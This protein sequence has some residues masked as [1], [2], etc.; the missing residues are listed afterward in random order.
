MGRGRN[1]P[2]RLALAAPK[3]A[4]S[5][6]PPPPPPQAPVAFFE[7]WRPGSVL[8]VNYDA[9][10]EP[11]FG[12]ILLQHVERRDW[13]AMTPDMVRHLEL[14]V[15][16]YLQEVR[17]GRRARELLSGV[18]VAFGA[19]PRVL[20]RQYVAAALA[21]ADG[22]SRSG[23]EA[24][25]SS[26]GQVPAAVVR[27]A[28]AGSWGP[29]RIVGGA[30]SSSSGPALATVGSAPGWCSLR[31]RG[32]EDGILHDERLHRGHALLFVLLGYLGYIAQLD[33]GSLS[34][35][36]GM[37]GQLQFP[38]RGAQEA[39]GV[40]F[41]YEHAAYFIGCARRAGG[42]IIHPELL[43][44]I[45]NRIHTDYTYLTE[46]REVAEERAPARAP[47]ANNA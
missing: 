25:S 13:V 10:Q 2:P 21:A 45:A 27:V 46:P 6:S 4:W 32:Y 11:W 8:Y 36:G 17:E 29:P 1:W 42:V 44:W 24:A 12:R 18:S 33:I 38:R 47:P 14:L 19:V 22:P 16:L 41:H 28:V 15:R 23:E 9:L 35:A 43:R 20:P 30:A 3:M 5:S 40:Q 7:N 34:G 26:S 39:Q 31:L 37:G